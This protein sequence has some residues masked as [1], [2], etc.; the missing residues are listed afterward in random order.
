[1]LPKRA[2]SVYPHVSVKLEVKDKNGKVL[3]TVVK[4][5]DMILQNW[6]E[7]ILNFIMGNGTSVTVKDYSG[8][9]RTLNLSNVLNTEH[10]LVIYIGTSSQ[11]P[12][13]TDYTLI[14]PYS[15]SPTVVVTTSSSYVT[16]VA[17]ITC[18][19]QQTIRETGLSALWKIS[20]GT[21]AT[22][23]LLRDTPTAV[24][25][26]AGKTITVTYTFHF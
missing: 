13:R 14:A 17:S 24:V 9:N 7:G 1:M 23:L 3:K 21:S 2:C 5:N 4:D 11:A 8:V 19:T 22:I 18:G 16:Y 15:S 26:P 6:R 12:S 10:L 20:T 25:V